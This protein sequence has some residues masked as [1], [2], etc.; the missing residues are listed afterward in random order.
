MHLQNQ[1]I[2]RLKIIKK[3]QKPSL[4][5]QLWLFFGGFFGVFSPKALSFSV[6][7]LSPEIQQHPGWLSCCPGEQL[8]ARFLPLLCLSFMFNSVNSPGQAV[9][10]SPQTHNHSSGHTQGLSPAE[11]S[12]C[13][14]WI[15]SKHQGAGSCSM[16]LH[17]SAPAAFHTHSSFQSL[18]KDFAVDT[19]NWIHTKKKSLPSGFFYLTQIL[20]PFFLSSSVRIFFQ[21]KGD[22]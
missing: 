22:C 12:Q 20:V 4:L 10:Q 8:L 11:L 14:P 6:Q 1:S 19:R 9:P 18:K 13:Q 3:T 5:L 17:H 21:D 2:D 7:M 16:A 15:N